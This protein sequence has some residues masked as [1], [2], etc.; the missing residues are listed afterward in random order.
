MFLRAKG[1]V[2]VDRRVQLFDFC[3]AYNAGSLGRS[4]FDVPSVRNSRDH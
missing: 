1:F 4:L 2:R 3:F